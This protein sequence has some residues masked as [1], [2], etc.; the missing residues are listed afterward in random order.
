MEEIQVG[1]YARTKKGLIAKLCAYQDL[2]TYDNNNISVTFHSFDTDKGA[3]A[4]IEVKN[5]ST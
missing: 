3:I 2:T 1:E 4:D 5:H